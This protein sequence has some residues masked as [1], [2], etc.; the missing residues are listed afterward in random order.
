MWW[1]GRA[2]HQQVVKEEDLSL[3][4][5][6]LLGFVGVGNLEE[7]AITHQPP[8]GQGEDLHTRTHAH[9]HTHTHTHTGAISAS[10][11]GTSNQS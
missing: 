2:H 7:T 9:T 3:V 11:T 8:V 5:A 1:E 4:H 10:Q 6:Q